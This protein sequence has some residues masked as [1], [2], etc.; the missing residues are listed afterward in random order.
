MPDNIV[1]IESKIEQIEK[2]LP[3]YLPIK[4]TKSNLS[5]IDKKIKDILKK[6]IV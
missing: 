3:L 6:T 2:T 1:R 5:E 4:R